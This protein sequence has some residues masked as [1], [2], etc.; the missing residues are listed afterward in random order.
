MCCKFFFDLLKSKMPRK[1]DFLGQFIRYFVTGG[2]A[3]VA[4]FAFFAVSVYCL[5]IHYLVANLIGLLAGGSVNYLLS[6]GWVFSS[7]KRR[8][9]KA[10]VLEMVVFVAICLFGM[11][12]NEGLM[13]LFVGKLAI[14][15]MIAKALAT[16]IV[17]M[18]NFLAR[19]FILFGKKKEI[20]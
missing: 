3:T 9:E 13:Y 5:D 11:A 19:K 1:E 10:R 15:D 8:L 12:F 4:D 16:I 2:L 17:F 7:E 14:Q 6:F 18:W 20:E